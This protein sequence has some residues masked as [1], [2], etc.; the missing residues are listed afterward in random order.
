M[1]FL[2]MRIATAKLEVIPYNTRDEPPIKDFMK[3]ILLAALFSIAGL[4]ANAAVL[5][6]DDIP[7]SSPNNVGDM[8]AA[9]K[10]FVF[11]ETSDWIDTVGSGWNYGTHSGE[12]VLLNNNGGPIIVTAA[13]ASDFTFDGVWAETWAFA[14]SRS[15]TISGFN[16]GAQVWSQQIVI[17]PSFAFFSGMAG[18]IDQL[19]L[20]L[21]DFFL[22]DDLALSSAPAAAA[23][24]EPGS[25]ALLGLGVAGLAAARRRK[26][27]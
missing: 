10:G 25:L 11:N 23:I 17:A 2:G 8:P 20:N 5:S 4:N 6:F 22:I 15:G 3:S 18:K 19:Q 12:F 24:P 9:Y 14:A 27:A 13:D 21:G 7:T 26:R 1:F 16:N